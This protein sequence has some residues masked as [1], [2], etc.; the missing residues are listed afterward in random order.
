ME[1]QRLIE[2]MLP[3]ITQDT[4]FD[5]GWIMTERFAAEQWEYHIDVLKKLFGFLENTYKIIHIS[6][7]RKLFYM[8]KEL[9]LFCSHYQKVY[10]WSRL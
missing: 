6:K 5:I 8:V 7:S 10:I 1:R 2:R 3:Y 9:P 4:G